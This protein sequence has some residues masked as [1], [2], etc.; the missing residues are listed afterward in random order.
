MRWTRNGQ[1]PP[2]GSCCSRCASIAKSSPPCCRR[3]VGSIPV[4]VPTRSER[5]HGTALPGEVTSRCGGCC[6]A[7]HGHRPVTTLY[8]RSSAS[9]ISHLIPLSRSSSVLDFIYYPVSF[10]LWCWHQVFGF[11]FTYSSAISWVLAIA[12]VT[13]T[14]RGIMFKPFVNQ[15]RSMKKMQD[16]A[17]EMKKV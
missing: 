5:G 2:H 12:F 4:A 15:V 10:I 13:F 11:I 8:R 7:V 9:P 17:P 16:F 6:V 14:I 1:L 3:S